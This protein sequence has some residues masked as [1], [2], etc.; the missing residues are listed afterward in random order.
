MLFKA[1]ALLLVALSTAQAFAPAA[2]APKLGCSHKSVWPRPAAN[3]DS[4]GLEPDSLAQFL[5]CRWCG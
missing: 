5:E 1:G 2:F 4:V 3:H